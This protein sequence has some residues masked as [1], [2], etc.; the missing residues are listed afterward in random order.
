V[1]SE[2][3]RFKPFTEWL[4]ADESVYSF[5]SGI[6]IPPPLA[7]IPLKRL[8]SGDMSSDRL[9]AELTKYKPG[10]MVLANDSRERPF[11]DLLDRE[12]R[13]VYEDSEDRLFALRSITGK[14]RY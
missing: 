3:A 9:N 13:L 14:A 8:W 7:V 5:H 6:P 10:L 11:Q 2:I 12:Y 1:L 4:Y